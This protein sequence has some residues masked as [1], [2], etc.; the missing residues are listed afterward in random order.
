MAPLIDYSA[1]SLINGSDRS[2]LLSSTLLRILSAAA[3][4]PGEQAGMELEEADTVMAVDGVSVDA[5]RLAA[6]ARL[7]LA[8][9]TERRMSD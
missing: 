7:V 1:W 4:A 9:R 3:A 5:E 2:L 6:T 8:Q